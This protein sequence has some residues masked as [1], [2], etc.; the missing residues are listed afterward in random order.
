LTFGKTLKEAKNSITEALELYFE[1]PEA[2][3][4]TPV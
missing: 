3:E 4:L 2:G 1:E